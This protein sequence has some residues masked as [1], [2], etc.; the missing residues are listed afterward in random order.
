MAIAAS[1]AAATVAQAREAS[2]WRARATLAAAGW[3]T[4]AQLSLGAS[5]FFVATLRA[6]HLTL[7]EFGTFALASTLVAFLSVIADFGLSAM[8]VRDLARHGTDAKRYLAGSMTLAAALGAA[9]ACGLIAAGAAFVQGTELIALCA[10]LSISV[11]SLALSI[12]PAAYLRVTGRTHIEA[13]SRAV[14][15]V[16]LIAL[17]VVAVVLH[18]G[19][20]AYAWA[21]AASAVVGLAVQMAAL[22]SMAGR[23]V[24]RIDRELSTRLLLDSAPIGFARLC[25]GVYYYADSLIL[26]GFGQSTALARY[27]AS[28]TFVFACSLLI[29]AIRTA[30]MPAQSRAFAGQGELEPVLRAYLRLSLLFAVPLLIVGPLA[31]GTLLQIVYGASFVPATGALRLL[32]MTAGVMFLSSYFGSNLL[33][34]G[35]QRTYLGGTAGGAVVNIALNIILIPAYSLV[36]AAAATLVAESA[37]C[38]FFARENARIRSIPTAARARR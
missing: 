33:L 36:G 5:T 2:P 6:R 25:T 15:G 4:L 13:A 14:A 30:F 26:A 19:V 9:A 23:I 12:G 27:N 37:I 16:V 31:S 11:L 34:S 17:T 38:L 32:M 35:R 28:Y 18:A 29:T 22:L 7:D 3:L 20:A 8:M 24:P 1:S 10:V 21:F